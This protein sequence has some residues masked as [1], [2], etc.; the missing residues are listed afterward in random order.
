MSFVGM[1]WV[2]HV[3]VISSVVVWLGKL[4][5]DEMFLVFLKMILL[6]VRDSY[7]RSGGRQSVSRREH[8]GTQWNGR[9]TSSAGWS[10]NV[11]A[12]TN[13]NHN[14]WNIAF[15]AYI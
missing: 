12:G 13:A 1:V 6:S 11:L 3:C 5:V 8:R 9:D 10:R 15:V 2:R 7:N 14:L 4:W